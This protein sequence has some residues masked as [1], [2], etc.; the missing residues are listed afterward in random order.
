LLL[1]AVYSRDLPSPE[2]IK[3]REGFSTVILDRNHKTIYD[4]FT[5]RN[6][7]PIKFT[8]MPDHLK[9]A[10]IAIEDSNF[11]SNPAFDWKAIARAVLV[12]LRLREGYIGQGGS[13]ITQQLARNAFLSSEP[14]FIKN[15]IQ[16]IL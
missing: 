4:I 12:N 5:D 11:Y 2:K 9:K 7:I 13:T 1:F 15:I 6:T 8:E 3:R 10:T 16:T 14:T